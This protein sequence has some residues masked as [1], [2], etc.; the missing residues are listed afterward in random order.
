MTR[1]DLRSRNK[2]SL[3]DMARRRKIAGAIRMT[4]EQLISQL[5]SQAPSKPTASSSK[6]KASKPAP[7]DPVKSSPA[8]PASASVSSKK[9]GRAAKAPLQRQAARDTTAEGNRLNGGIMSSP[10][11]QPRHSSAKA[12]ADLPRSYGRDRLVLLVRDPYWLHCYWEISAQTS[13]QA[14]AALGVDW[15]TARRALRLVGVGGS[16]GTSSAESIIKDIFLP[17]ESHNWY[18]DVP[19]SGSNYQVE[20]GFKTQGGRFYSMARSNAVAT[21]RAELGSAPSQNW[22]EQDAK[23]ADKLFALSTGLNGHGNSAEV[24]QF[25]EERMG[26]VPGSPTLTSLGSGGFGHLGKGRQF[27][28]NID[29]DLVVYGS[30]EP[31]AR[32][33]FQGEPVTLRPDGSF[34]LRFRLADGRHILPALAVSA[35]GMEERTIVLAVERNTKQMEPVV[36]EDEE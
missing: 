10:I 23:S 24:R 9:S 14:E 13:R 15:A 7:K 28:F 25:F 2:E 22:T 36:H 18:I 21:P 20:I 31:N 6:T 19:N 29:A 16:E 4:R 1:K 11:F 27:F 32:V 5:T 35:T 33:T 3:V 34:S 12:P 26:R 30:T 17:E 8:K